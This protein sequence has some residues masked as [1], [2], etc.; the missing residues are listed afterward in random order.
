M[1]HE[2]LFVDRN[3]LDRYQLLIGSDIDYLI[4]HKERK[5]MRNNFSDFLDIK[6]HGRSFPLNDSVNYLMSSPPSIWI[7]WPVMYWASRLKRN[8]TQDAISSGRPS[9]P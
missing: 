6:L 8:L 7:T 4:D 9:R 3:V 2:K 5:T 1:P